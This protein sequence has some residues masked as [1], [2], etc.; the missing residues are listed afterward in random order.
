MNIVIQPLYREQIA[1]DAYLAMLAIAP[2]YQ[3]TQYEQE[4]LMLL[5]E[6]RC[7][8]INK[9]VRINPKKQITQMAMGF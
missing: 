6:M 4:A 3:G 9:P 7:K 8:L 2:L 5:E 1:R